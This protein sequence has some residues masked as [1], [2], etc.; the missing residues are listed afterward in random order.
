METLDLRF[1]RPSR[2]SAPPRQLDWMCTARAGPRGTCFVGSTA[3]SSFS[4][5]R[6][7]VSSWASLRSRCPRSTIHSESKLRRCWPKKGAHTSWPELLQV[8]QTGSWPSHF[9]FL[10]V[11]CWLRSGVWQKSLPRTSSCSGCRHGGHSYHVSFL[12]GN[13]ERSRKMSRRAGA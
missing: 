13:A 5:S 7:I 2:H 8:E 12:R 11:L 9:D 3:S 1:S 4:A 10:R 6:H